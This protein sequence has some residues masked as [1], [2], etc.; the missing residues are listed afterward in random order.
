MRRSTIH[1]P[2]WNLV[3][4]T[5]T[6]TVPVTAAPKLLMTIESRQPGLR[7]RHQRRTRPDCDSV[8]ARNTPI[9]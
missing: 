9:V 5:T 2:S 4:A 7:R 3:T 1:A 6:S 8:N